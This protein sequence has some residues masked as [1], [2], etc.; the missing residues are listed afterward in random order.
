MPKYTED[1]KEFWTMMLKYANS[2]KQKLYCNIC[3]R[4]IRSQTKQ[5]HDHFF[6][7]THPDNNIYEIFSDVEIPM[8]ELV[9]DPV[10]RVPL[11]REIKK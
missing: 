6:G 10:T 8:T 11:P 2:G 3:H 5:A 1:E 7:K 9:V 4:K